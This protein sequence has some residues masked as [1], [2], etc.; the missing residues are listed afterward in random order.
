MPYFNEDWNLK[1]QVIWDIA[2][3]APDI[4]RNL[5]SSSRVKAD[6]ECLMTYTEG[7]SVFYMQVD[8]HACT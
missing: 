1:I 8:A 7:F 5:L 4:H 6:L 2:R 3:G